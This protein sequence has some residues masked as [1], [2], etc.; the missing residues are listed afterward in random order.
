MRGGIMPRTPWASILYRPLSGV[1]P[2]LL[3]ARV[4]AGPAGD[5]LEQELGRSETRVWSAPLRLVEGRSLADMGVP[6]RLERLGY[7]RVS[8]RP[9]QPGEWFFGTE[10]AWVYRRAWRMGGQDW[11]ARLLGVAL[12]RDGRIA[13]G[14]AESG[15]HVALADRDGR[16]VNMARGLVALASG[17]PVGA[18]KPLQ[19]AAAALSPR[20]GIVG[21]GA[22]HVP[23]WSAVGEALLQSGRPA[24]ALPWFEKVATSGYERVR[25]PIPFVR[26]FYFLGQIHEKQGDKLRSQEAYRRFVSYWKD[27]DLD[28]AR[29]AEAQ[30]KISS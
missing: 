26:S 12:S 8:G 16:T 15:A 21:G 30:R 13:S 9:E 4:L 10:R 7:R 3:A 19:D 1:L 6:Q 5:G 14:L 17:D 29:V 18:V 20:S 25:Q 24:E 28:R 11:P 22:A 2:C 27:G 23:I